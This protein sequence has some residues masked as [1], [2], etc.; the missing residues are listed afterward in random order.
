V[1]SELEIE[2]R[3]MSKNKNVGVKSGGF[4]RRRLS[5]LIVIIAFST[6]FLSYGYLYFSK[7]SRKEATP[8]V[9]PLSALAWEDLV[10]HD[11][12]E[13]MSARREAFFRNRKTL[14]TSSDDVVILTV[15][16][17]E[18]V[19]VENRKTYARRHGLHY[20][21][22]GCATSHGNDIRST[23]PRMDTGKWQVYMCLLTLF[24]ETKAKWYL[25]MDNDAIF[26]DMDR[27]PKSI[28]SELSNKAGETS[29]IFSAEDMASRPNKRH[30]FNAGVFLARIFKNQWW[31][32]VIFFYQAWSLREICI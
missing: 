17:P 11:I 20:F 13:G 24:N 19:L 26:Y 5:T 9:I 12:I 8:R 10:F 6:V 22:C 27:E 7:H 4:L 3:R 16:D 18:K 31:E 2:L 30:A 15:G 28:I 32:R 25:Y 29:L 1:I 21:H 23:C 14:N